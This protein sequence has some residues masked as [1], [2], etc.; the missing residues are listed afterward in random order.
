MTDTAKNKQYISDSSLLSEWDWEKNTELGLDPEKLS[1]GSTKYAYW[2]CEKGHHYKAR[3]DHRF[4][5]KSGCPYCAGKIPINGENDLASQYPELIKEWNYNKNDKEPQDYI[6]GSNKKVWWICQKCG[7]EWQTAISH[8]TKRDTGCPICA[9]EQ[10]VNTRNKKF[11]VQ[12]GSLA[13]NMP[14]LC[15]EWDYQKN[16]PLIPDDVTIKSN[17]KVW[18][19]CQKCG[20]SYGQT[21]ANHSIGEGCP[22]C[23]GKNVVE[24]HNDLQSQRSKILKRKNAPLNSNLKH[25]NITAYTNKYVVKRNNNLQSQGINIPKEKS[26]TPNSDLKHKYITTYAN[27]YV[28][29][30]QNDLQSQCPDIVKEWHPT[31]NGELKP[32]QVTAYNDRRIWWHCSKCNYDWEAT[33]YSR[34][35]LGTGCPACAGRVVI[36]GKN[37]LSTTYPEI[38]KQ[39]HPT[40]NNGL[41]PSEVTAKSN[42]PVWW[43]CDKGH[44]WKTR[45]ATRTRGRGCPECAKV[46]RGKSRTKTTV[47][48]KGSLKDN[49][50]ELAKQ[51][52]PTKNKDLT[53]EMISSGSSKKVWWQC[54]LG[55]EWKANINSRTKG[56]GCPICAKESFTSYPEQIIFYYLSKVTRTINRYE[57]EG[58]EIDVFLPD[59]S[60]GIEYNSTYYHKDRR[61]SDIKKVSFFSQRGIKVIRIEEGEID[62]F[63][64]DVIIYKYKD[65]YYK[66]FEIIITQLLSRLSLPM[67]DVNI[68]RDSLEIYSSYLTD[69]GNESLAVQK[70]QIAKEWNYEKNKGLTPEQ[71]TYG[72]DIKVWWKCSKCNYEWVAAISSRKNSKCPQCHKKDL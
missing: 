2:I 49:Y 11:I 67:V 13:E 41:L 6:Y 48:K 50:P 26:T 14:E 64:D 39:W 70:P 71:V 36:K 65:K 52:H 25:K 54:E 66:D 47:L 1:H 23:A 62:T 8:R 72:S 27:K 51:W 33:I 20:L 16:A 56:N 45:I 19:I 15:A 40:K 69:K 61:D 42:K 60:V 53:P 4:I 5:M 30:G 10:R 68:E 34:T 29:E 44:E 55:H 32:N 59:L 12:R 63:D 58:N 21:V 9:K 22:A 31:L 38:A 3:I 37:D 7:H 46:N 28:V 17:K 35:G 18:W 43:L 24:G 57:I